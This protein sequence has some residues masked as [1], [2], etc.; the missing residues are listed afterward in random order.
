MKISVI[1][2]STGKKLNITIDQNTT[3]K[4]KLL[5]NPIGY[6]QLIP[7]EDYPN[8]N[9]NM[10]NMNYNPY[11]NMNNM[12]YNPYMNMNNMNYNPNMN[13]NNINLILI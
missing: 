2:R 8:M 7:L 11:M 4:Y 13:M 12:N 9:I 10:N 5:G 6:T 1:E 3:K